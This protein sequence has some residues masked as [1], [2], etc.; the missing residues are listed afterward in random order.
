MPEWT[1]SAP[2]VEA[3]SFKTGPINCNDY[4]CDPT[5]RAQ[6][7][8]WLWQSWRP[9]F[10]KGSDLFHIKEDTQSPTKKGSFWSEALG[11]WTLGHPCGGRW[12]LSTWPC[13]SSIQLWTS[14][15]ESLHGGIY[16]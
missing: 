14:E 3:L 1:V 15:E 5:G 7:N 12:S 4:F 8:S 13:A 16:F 2:D 11:F 6:T 10:I 9:L